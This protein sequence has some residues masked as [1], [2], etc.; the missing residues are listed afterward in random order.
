MSSPGNT[1]QAVPVAVRD[2]I[3][4]WLS[5]TY[6]SAPPGFPIRI[7]ETVPKPAGMVLRLEIDVNVVTLSPRRETIYMEVINGPGDTYEIDYST[8]VLFND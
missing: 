8:I 5:G 7:I 3:R 4:D 1:S 2:L 6:D